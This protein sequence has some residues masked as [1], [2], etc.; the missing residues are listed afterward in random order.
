MIWRINTG[1]YIKAEEI[2]LL[3]W[4]GGQLA[5]CWQAWQGLATEQ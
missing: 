3:V 1:M 4:I 2:V 5:V